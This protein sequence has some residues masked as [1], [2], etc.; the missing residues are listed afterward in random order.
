MKYVSDYTGYSGDPALQKGNFLAWA[1][2][3]SETGVTYKAWVEGAET[4]YDEAHAVTLDSDKD[5]VTRVHSVN[6]V[7]V[8]K[9]TKE[10]RATKIRRISFAGLTLAED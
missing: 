3:T 10:G 2:D 6:E 5:A 7:L 4:N 8:V 9:A 1:V